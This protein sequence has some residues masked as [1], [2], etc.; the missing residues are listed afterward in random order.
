[1]YKFVCDPETLFQMALA[2]SNAR[3]QV[4]LEPDEHDFNQHQVFIFLSIQYPSIY[5][6]GRDTPLDISL[7]Y[8]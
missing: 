8:L 6:A 5:L 2:D 4:K 3:E 1:M 7:V